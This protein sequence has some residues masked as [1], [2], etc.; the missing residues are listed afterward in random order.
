MGFIRDECP[1]C[2]F[3]VSKA[4]NFCSQCGS[5]GTGGVSKCRK[6]GALVSGT[7]KFC[8]KCSH[9]LAESGGPVIIENKWARSAED[10]AARASAQELKGFL[11]KGLEVE[12]GTMALLLRGGKIGKELTP[13]SYNVSPGD[14]LIFID[15]GD[16]DLDVRVA[17]LFT[18]DDQ[19][20]NVGCKMFL[21]VEEP[22][23]FFEN[24]IGGRYRFSKY[25][26]EAFV[27]DELRSLVEP[28]VVS[29][30][31]EELQ[32]DDVLKKQM[33]D[34]V[35]KDLEAALTPYGFSLSRLRIVSPKSEEL[36]KLRRERGKG[37]LAEQWSE[38]YAQVRERLTREK[39]EELKDE[40][41]FARFLKTIQQESGIKDLVLG[42]EMEE[43]KRTFEERK[44]NQ[45]MARRHILERINLQHEIELERIDLTGKEETQNIVADAR[46]QRRLAEGE[47]RQAEERAEAR[48][49]TESGL[50]LQKGKAE[51][52]LL[53]AETEAKKAR[54]KAEIAELNTRIDITH[55]QRMLELDLHGRKE[56]QATEIAG[57]ERK[58]GM[59]VKLLPQAGQEAADKVLQI[60]SQHF[61][62]SLPS[63]T[64]RETEAGSRDPG[65]NKKCKKCGLEFEFLP[66]DTV[67]PS[68]G[69][70]LM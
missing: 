50:I 48:G 64:E 67:C 29:H 14:S 23:V 39:M 32:K 30:N 37:H 66:G 53:M 24:L 55:K 44:I 6:C 36:E 65:L 47:T 28:T 19:L 26:L 4:A 21:K 34:D 43:L 69:Q 51:Q 8:W 11:R 70:A 63:G 13:G 20:V 22:K 49:K 25:D 62:P 38:L 1:N 18:R 10:I 15:L 59:L 33:Q 46:R 41:D 57:L 7:S 3:W 68:C 52:E 56:K 27:G 16:I 60:I 42:A 61:F 31:I 17:N 5:K 9:D 35:R 12:S 58:V 54:I 45:E 40:D 2:G